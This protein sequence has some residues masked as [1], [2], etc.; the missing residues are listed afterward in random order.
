MENLV[1]VVGALQ[2]IAELVFDDDVVVANSAA[3]AFVACVGY[4]F[5]Q[6]QDPSLG[7]NEEVLTTL[8]TGASQH[9]RCLVR[10]GANDGSTRPNKRRRMIWQHARATACIKSDYL[11]PNPLFNDRQFERIF[12]ITRSMVE[13]LCQVCARSDNFFLQRSDAT[14]KP[15]IPVETKV[16]MGLKCLAFGV[17]PASYQDYFQM[18]ESTGRECIKRLT[19]A[20]VGAPELCEVYLRQMTRSDALRV[21]EMHFQQHGVRGLMGALDCWHWIWK[22]CPV[23]WQGQLQGKEG[24]P[25]MVLE[26]LSDYSLWIWSAVFGYPGTMNDINIWERSPLLKA[27]LDGS[28]STNVD[29]EFNIGGK[30]FSELWILVDGIYPELSRFVKSFD[31]PVGERDKMYVG[32]Q[33]SSRKSVER[34]FGVLQRKFQILERK[35]ELWYVEDIHQVVMACVVLHNMMVAERVARDEEEHSS[36][37]VTIP[38]DV[39]PHEPEQEDPIHE[40]AARREAE[41]DLHQRLLNMARGPAPLQS[42]CN[43]EMQRTN[44][45]LERAISMRWKSLYDRDGHHRLREAI[46][47]ELQSLSRLCSVL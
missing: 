33:E 19:R 15:S 40:A 26:A 30:T 32:W 3:M 44:R 9:R 28:F 2:P 4:L 8:M 10:E 5:T 38:E 31:E 16:L 34:A 41:A 12:R 47:D 18:G 6:A 14:G 42:P 24:H 37:Y 45:V 39:T 22:N 17:S 35:V 11:G 36:L 43:E 27:F 46:K 29:F 21:S 7:V 23:G 1:L 13:T 25:T 20:I